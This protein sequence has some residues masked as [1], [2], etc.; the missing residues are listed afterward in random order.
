MNRILELKNLTIGNKDEKIILKNI[1]LAINCGE[2]HAILGPNG[3]GKT[4]LLQTLMGSPFYKIIEGDINYHSKNINN[5]TPTSRSKEGIF[6]SFQN[7]TEIEGINNLDYIKSLLNLNSKTKKSFFEVYNIIEKNATNL[8]LPN[9]FLNR[10]LNFGF[11]GGEKKTFELF[12][13]KLK[14]PKLALIDEIDSGLDVDALKNVSNVINDLQ[15]NNNLSAI[16]VSHYEELYTKIKVN[17]FH[18]LLDGQI[19]CSG[20]YDLLRKIQK[21]GYDWIYKKYNIKRIEKSNNIEENNFLAS[22]GVNKN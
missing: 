4:T 14:K 17:K 12:Q 7:P 20:N 13:L 11:S 16:I 15:K 19:V 6:L 18:V 21:N 9:D 3:T 22:C 10:N 1:N 2:I 5:F 8:I